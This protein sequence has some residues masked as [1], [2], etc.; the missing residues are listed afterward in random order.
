MTPTF[1][2][3]AAHGDAHAVFPTRTSLI[4]F[5]CSSV[6]GAI[7]STHD[8]LARE[9]SAHATLAYSGFAEAAVDAVNVARAVL[10]EHLD[11]PLA[12]MDVDLCLHR[13]RGDTH[14]V[15][16]AAVV[17]WGNNGKPK[18]MLECSHALPAE[19]LKGLLRDAQ[20]QRYTAA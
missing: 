11:S 17:A 1:D 6:G 2:A 8:I 19:A 14:H 15:W 20:G 5:S 18:M 9:R 3:L 4:L 10:A 12:L 16:R 13:E 7:P